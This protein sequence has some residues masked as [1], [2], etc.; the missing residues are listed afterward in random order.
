VSKVTIRSGL[1]L[2]TQEIEG[3]GHRWRSDEP[4]PVGGDD[5]GPSPYLLLL[6]A[7]GSCTAITLQMYAQRKGWPL[8][9]LSLEVEG[10]TLPDVDMAGKFYEITVTLRLEGDLTP[11]QRQRL[12]DIASKCPVKKTL[13]GEIRVLNRLA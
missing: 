1:Q 4:K 10:V 13:T 12:L 5:Q 2:F 11:E 6:S 8:E 3:R 7:L 9:S